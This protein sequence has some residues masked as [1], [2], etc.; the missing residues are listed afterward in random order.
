MRSMDL[1]G[2]S[3]VALR[4]SLDRFLEIVF[5][6]EDGG[7]VV[8]AG[9][10]AGDD[11][12]HFAGEVGG[13]NADYDFAVELRVAGFGD[14]Q[15]VVAV[16]VV[17]G[18]VAGA[19]GLGCGD[20]LAVAGEGDFDFRERLAFGADEEAVEAPEVDGALGFDFGPGE[21]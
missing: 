15:P 5:V 11:V 16:D 8:G 4:V 7:A 12:E 17:E 10:G 20:G 18:E 1:F 6:E 3:V 21:R 19:V 14:V 2:S 9:A 13:F